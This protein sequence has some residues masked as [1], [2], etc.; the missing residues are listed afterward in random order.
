MAKRPG[1]EPV[2]GPDLQ[3]LFDKLPPHDLNAE[4]ALLGSL[5]L[6]GGDHLEIIGDCMEIIR[7]PGDFSQPRHQAVYDAIITTYDRHASVD[8]VQLTALLRDRGLYDDVGG[9][10]FLVDL[11]ESVPTPINAP[12]FAKI[13]RDKAVLRDLVYVC[14]DALREC[15]ESPEGCD[16]IVDRVETSIYELSDR[17]DADSGRSASI[18]DAVQHQ[19]HVMEQMAG[20][21]GVPGLITG[22]TS[23]D[24]LL[25]GF[26]EGEMITLAARPS[27]GKT[28]LALNIAEN[29]ACL[30]REPVGVM[31]MEMSRNELGLRFL[32]ARSKVDS[33][34]IRQNRITPD[35]MSRLTEAGKKF[36]TDHYPQGIVYEYDPEGTFTLRSVGARDVE[37]L[38]PMGIPYR[39]PHKVEG[40]QTWG[41]ADG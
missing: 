3:R 1:Y 6:A 33:A 17:G 38:C 41:K 28:A 9:M 15:H 13:V 24:E 4:M 31:S 2:S 22:Y 7:G 32:S 20:G 26:H 34:R 27:M 21:G 40:E 10:D 37:L 18:A 5:I 25:L 16:D 19:F 30:N 8:S 35:E 23:L 39:L 36:M 29:V 14:G 12:R 11:C